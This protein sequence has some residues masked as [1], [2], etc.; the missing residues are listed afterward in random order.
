ML[1]DAITGGYPAEPSDVAW[2]TASWP[3]ADVPDG[4]VIDHLIEAAFENGG[5]M[6]TTNSVIVVQRGRIVAERYAG[7]LGSFI[8]D[9]VPVTAETPLLSWSM[10]KTMLGTLVGMLVD[11]GRLTLDAAAPVAEWSQP[12]DIRGAITLRHLLEMRDGLAYVEDYVDGAASDV[13]EMLFGSGAGDTAHFTAS[14]PLAAEPGTR[15]N[16][17]SGTTNV[18][19]RIVGD[20]VGGETA[21]RQFLSER[22]FEP[23]SMHSAVPTFDEAGTFI[24]S[25]YVHATAQ[26]FARFGLMLCRGGR[27]EGVQVVPEW[28][29]DEMRTPRSID[30]DDGWL[31]SVQTWVADDGLGTFWCNGFEG[32]RIVVCPAKD[33][34]IVRT[35]TTPSEQNPAL[36]AW[37]A[38]LVAAFPLL[39]Q[40]THAS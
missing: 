23:C 9:P 28:W 2:P 11:E 10:A 27:A 13:I 6:A 4:V 38:D 19:S 15:F 26:D 8:G 14:K 31:Y 3:R 33:L 36:Q 37:Q 24:A 40:T 25:S 32:Q 29:I 20:L 39:D 30:P 18:I 5:P 1:P 12:G 21:M 16:Y 7:A 34:V 22:L 35:G 17:S